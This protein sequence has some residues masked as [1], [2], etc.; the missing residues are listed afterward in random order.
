[1]SRHVVF[2]H[3]G[4]QLSV[5][6]YTLAQNTLHRI[7]RPLVRHIF[8]CRILAIM[9]DDDIPYEDNAAPLESIVQSPL[10]Q[11]GVD[12][13]LLNIFPETSIQV[14]R[15]FIRSVS[16]ANG[17]VE[18][19]ASG[20]VSKECYE[21][22]LQSRAAT[23]SNPTRV[24]QRCV[25][26]H[27]TASDGRQAFTLEEERA[28]LRVIRQKAVWPA[29]QDTSVTIGHKGFRVL[30]F[31][32]RGYIAET[33]SHSDN[34][35]LPPSASS[36]V[37]SDFQSP[38]LWQ[39]HLKG[40]V[41]ADAFTGTISPQFQS[42]L[43]PANS[44]PPIGLSLPPS[45]HNMF[46]LGQWPPNII[47]E[48]I[49][50]DVQ[51]QNCDSLLQIAF[52]QFV[53]GKN[54]QTSLFETM[55]PLKPPTLFDAVNALSSFET[56]FNNFCGL[57][58]DLTAIGKDEFILAQTQASVRYIGPVARSQPNAS[59]RR[60]VPDSHLINLARHALYC[61][62]FAPGQVVTFSCKVIL[63]PGEALLKLMM[64]FLNGVLVI[65][66]HICF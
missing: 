63:L 56:Q 3:L 47:T 14:F 12:A 44:S 33:E 52:L 42:M 15:R 65:G 45:S 50:P 4:S 30:G 2:V 25:T 27:I 23:L 31:H 62:R 7:D 53:C 46:I 35:T 34:E 13:N 38:A 17:A 48:E 19:D 61:T 21:A 64:C 66:G 57:A 26:A 60:L 1:M 10:Q 54:I 9:I 55:G 32:E 59:Y 36:S 5:G 39:H 43:M 8:C 58:L 41:N 51:V 22:W 40:L 18:L 28:I 6:Y 20:V 11:S 37:V 49:V 24:F 16:L 29:F